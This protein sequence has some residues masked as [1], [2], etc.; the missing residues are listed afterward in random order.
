MELNVLILL[1]A[2]IIYNT[3]TFFVY[4][5]DKYCA[6]KSKWRVP[7]KILIL[8]AFVFGGIGAFLG[9]RLF[10]HKTKHIKFKILIPVFLVAQIIILFVFMKTVIY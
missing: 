10:R 5:Y 9:M 2:F 8:M 1:F 3:I 4:G 7:E 6:K